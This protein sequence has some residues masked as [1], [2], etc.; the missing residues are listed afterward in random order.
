MPQVAIAAMAV[1]TVMQATQIRAAGRTDAN[2]TEYER[3]Q[4]LRNARLTEMSGAEEVGQIRRRAE[5]L[6]AEQRAAFAA[7]GVS[8]AG[9]SPLEVMSES[10]RLAEEDAQTVVR[11]TSVR[12]QGFYDDA[13][14]AR[15]RKQWIR[16]ATRARMATSLLMG[17]AQT[18]REAYQMRPS[19][20]ARDAALFARHTAN[21]PVRR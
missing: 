14:L 16:R 4:A 19:P 8:I 13:E 5:A 12:A 15:Q 11:D 10:A 1:G 17:A 2:M 7:S 21:A 9:G 3:Q 6:L 18:G 20:A